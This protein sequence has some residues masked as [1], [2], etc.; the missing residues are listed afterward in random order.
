MFN[1]TKEEELEFFQGSLLSAEDYRNNGVYELERIEALFSPQRKQDI[2]SYPSILASDFAI[3]SR[4]YF[5][6]KKLPESELMAGVLT[7]FL[8]YLNIEPEID[9]YGTTSGVFLRRELGDMIYYRYRGEDYYVSRYI[10]ASFLYHNVC[11]T[12][13]IE[14]VRQDYE[15]SLLRRV[16]SYPHRGEKVDGQMKIMTDAVLAMDAIADKNGLKVLI[17]GSSHEP[18]IVPRSAYAPLFYMT[19]NSTFDMYDPYEEEGEMIVNTNR[20][21]RHRKP[22]IGYDVENYDLVLDDAWTELG[23]RIEQYMIAHTRKEF[24][25][26]FKKHY[27]LKVFKPIMQG[28]YYYQV[29]RTKSKEMRYVSR[30]IIP[31][32]NISVEK[33]LGTCAF[34]RELIYYLREEEY[35]PMFFS[36]IA[37]CHKDGDGMHIDREFTLMWDIRQFEVAWEPVEVDLSN[38][39]VLVSDIGMIDREFPQVELRKEHLRDQII[40]VSMP[41]MVTNIVASEAKLII[42]ENGKGIEKAV[43][44]FNVE[45]V[46]ATAP[47]KESVVVVGETSNVQWLSYDKWNLLEDRDTVA[48]VSTLKL[49]SKE[50]YRRISLAAIVWFRDIRCGKEVIRRVFPQ[51]N[52]CKDYVATAMGERARSDHVKYI[53]TKMTRVSRNLER[54]YFQAKAAKMQGIQVVWDTTNYTTFIESLTKE[55][56][57]REKEYL[58]RLTK[59]KEKVS[60]QDVKYED[61]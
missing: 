40:M 30:D 51:Q 21:I 18:G 32:R 12:G 48:R 38:V 4:Q 10:Y 29:G 60:K 57:K 44:Y 54:S 17:I 23:T 35:H 13:N 55:R 1:L 5:A 6:M 8:E 19:T 47:Y 20:I 9:L 43:P 7:C 49:S 16:P 46:P 58:T 28:R 52:E 15:Q 37:R 24:K 36:A 42:R 45:W 14:Q 27:S 33:H 3:D 34:C 22:Y 50:D 26:K 59:F 2:I 25:D 31:A 39:K 11:V 53:A 61:Y 56:E 41:M